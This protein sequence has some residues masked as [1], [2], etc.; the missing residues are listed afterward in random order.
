MLTEAAAISWAPVLWASFASIAFSLITIAAPPGFDSR[1]LPIRFSLA[2]LASGIV[3]GFGDQAAELKAPLP[4]SLNARAG[5]RIV[6]L[7]TVWVI[8]AVI[9]LSIVSIR[10]VGHAWS[11]EPTVSVT[12]PKGRFLVEGFALTGIASV[13]GAAVSRVRWERFAML[14]AT[15][16]VTL[17]LLSRALPIEVTPWQRLGALSWRSMTLGLFVVGALGW[18]TA[19]LLTWDARQRF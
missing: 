11:L 16:F 13:L 5:A 15:A 8:S 3:F 2:M 4:T 10:I 14:G 7:G 12:F 6:A 18:A 1:E 9:T 17:F 19:M